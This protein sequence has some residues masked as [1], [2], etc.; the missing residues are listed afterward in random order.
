MKIAGLL[1][2]GPDGAG[3]NT[4]GEE[5]SKVKKQGIDID[6]FCYDK[7]LYAGGKNEVASRS[8]GFIMFDSYRKLYKQLKTYD[9]VIVITP[10]QPKD[11]LL[12]DYLTMMKHLKV[13]KVYF[14]L[15][16]TSRTVTKTIINPEHVS[17][18][19]L[20]LTFGNE[21]TRVFQMLKEHNDNVKQFDFN[22]FDY[23]SHDGYKKHYYDKKNIIS[24][25]GRYANFKGYNKIV[26]YASQDKLDLDAYDFRIQGGNYSYVDG[27]LSTTIGI[28]AVVCDSVKNKQIL[29]NLRLH[30]DYSDYEEEFYGTLDLFP[31]YNKNDILKRMA[32][33]K[34]SLFPI[35]Y[36]AGNRNK[37]AFETAMEYTMLESI[38]VGTPLIIT[39]E[40]AKEF[41]VMGKSLYEQKDECGLV[42]I[43]SF[44][45]II[46]KCKLYEKE[47]D[48]NVKKMQK[49]FSTKYSNNN[50]INSLLKEI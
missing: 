50:K 49:F 27:K 43:D 30:N 36:E 46:N 23:S 34:F 1:C 11:K 4:L 21:D 22:F 41:K 47:Y 13:K 25:F 40:Y 19:D 45:S 37:G 6:I 8:K 15:D 14:V 42:I 32:E 9:V 5:F 16:R 12:K 33:C 39:E 28:L 18:F 31:S 10:S 26:K 35:K 44:D 29:K 3:G 24:Y 17:Y 38:A 48:K 2:A 7:N 20:V